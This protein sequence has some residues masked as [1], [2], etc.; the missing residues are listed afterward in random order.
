MRSSRNPTECNSSSP[1]NI[2]HSKTHRN[3]SRLRFLIAK[4]LIDLVSESV[5]PADVRE[6]LHTL[7]KGIDDVHKSTYE[8]RV[9]KLEPS[10]SALAVKALSWITHAKRPLT[11]LEL[12][13]AVSFRP[14]MANITAD[15]LVAAEDILL[16]CAGLIV[17]EGD[18]HHLVRFA[19][20]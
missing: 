4:L 11:V 13:H 3:E 8:D 12:R 6:A 18:G 16:A 20:T 7:P 14:G 17:F 5:T 2:N 15:D 19:R 9:L 1:I 10:L